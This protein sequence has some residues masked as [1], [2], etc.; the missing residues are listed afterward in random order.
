MMISKK[1]QQ[2]T[3]IHDRSQKGNPP[4]LNGPPSVKIFLYAHKMIFSLCTHTKNII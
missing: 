4:F 2:K 1:M 3:I